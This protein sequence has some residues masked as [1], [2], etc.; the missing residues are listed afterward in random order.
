MS[1]TKKVTTGHY[2]VLFIIPNKFTEEESKEIVT[3]VEEV[4]TKTGN[5]ITFREYWGKKKLAYE[6]KHN[7]YGYY[8]LAEF[9]AD[10]QA[11]HAINQTLRLSTDVLRHQIVSKQV[12]SEA[13]IARAKTIQVK[14]DAKREEEAKA[15]KKKEDNKEGKAKAEKS[16]KEE[17]KDS[18][19]NM[20]DLDQKLEGILSAK[21]LM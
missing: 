11:V 17:K 9:D 21:D 8:A 2:E 10:K 13:D 4:I 12:K 18:K 3:K 20:K 5:E 6:I 19:E 1:K 16:P 15:N 14:I 7:S